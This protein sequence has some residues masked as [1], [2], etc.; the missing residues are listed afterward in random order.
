VERHHPRGLFAPR[1][2]PAAPSRAARAHH[3]SL[4]RARSRALLALSSY[5]H[6]LSLS[7][8]R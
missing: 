4:A 3:F 1:V 5:F 7:L 6:P 8:G 2:I